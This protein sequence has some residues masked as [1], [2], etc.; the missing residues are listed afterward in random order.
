MR[1]LKI[2]RKMLEAE[3]PTESINRLNLNEEEE[4]WYKIGFNTAKSRF[5]GLIDLLEDE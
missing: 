5:E 1:I 2:L 4:K 3:K